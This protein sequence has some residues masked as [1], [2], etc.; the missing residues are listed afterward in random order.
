MPA[1]NLALVVILVLDCHSMSVLLILASH[2]T[3]I[4]PLA[5]VLAQPIEVDPQSALPVGS[6]TLRPFQIDGDFIVII[7]DVGECSCWVAVSIK[8][9][10]LLVGEKGLI[11]LMLEHLPIDSEPSIGISYEFVVITDGSDDFKVSILH[12]IALS[13]S[14][15]LHLPLIGSCAG[16]ADQCFHLIALPVDKKEGISVAFQL[17]N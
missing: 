6:Y 9:V 8:V 14:D 5:V 12:V 7:A 3:F 17:R 15:G 13:G 10:V 1:L 2:C 4:D 16:N 11:V